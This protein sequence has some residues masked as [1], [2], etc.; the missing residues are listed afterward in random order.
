MSSK[1]GKKLLALLLATGLCASLAA[2]A[3]AASWSSPSGSGSAFSYFWNLLFGGGQKGSFETIEDESTVAAGTELR[4][5][6]Y[7]A[8]S[9]LAADGTT[10]KC[11]PVTLYNHDQTTFNNAVHQVE[12]DQALA[13]GGI[14]TLTKWQGVY[15]GDLY[16][17][18]ESYSY[19]SSEATYNSV[20]VSYNQNNS[21]STYTKGNYLSLIHI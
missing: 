15:F 6:T 2:P 21:Y 3:Y 11:F 16:G 10:L 1:F 9:T 7:E 14:N 17:K 5:N 12:V 19:T 18:S 8:A 4:A 20:S 13:N